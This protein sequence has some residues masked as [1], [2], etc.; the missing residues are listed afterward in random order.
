MTPTPFVGEWARLQVEETD[1]AGGI[2]MRRNRLNRALEAMTNSE[3]TLMPWSNGVAA[4]RAAPR[5]SHSGGGDV[6]WPAGMAPR[7]LNYSTLGATE[8]QR[9]REPAQGEARRNAT[10]SPASRASLA[11]LILSELDKGRTPYRTAGS[12]ATAIGL[13]RVDVESFLSESPD[14]RRSLF[15]QCDGAAVYT[16]RGHKVTPCEVL[17]FLIQLTLNS[18]R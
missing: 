11:N 18:Y 3:G 5:R 2:G 9:R 17:V 8:L 16:L 14:V 13:P 1:L 10:G 6:P 7:A 15:R 4:S 12:I